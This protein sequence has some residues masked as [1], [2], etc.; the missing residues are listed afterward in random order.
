[1]NTIKF[2]QTFANPAL[3]NFF[4][5]FTNLGGETLGVIFA[6]YFLWFKD[7]RYGYKLAFGLSFS[8]LINNFIKIIVN[9]PRPIGTKGIR[10]LAVNTA[11]GTSFPSGHSQGNA[12]TFTSLFLQFKTKKVLLISI[13]MM[14]LIPISRLYLGVHWPIDVVCGSIFGIIAVLISNFIYEQAIKNNIPYLYLI[15]SIILLLSLIL[16]RS[17][18]YIKAIGGFISISLGYYIDTKY[19]KYNPN[20]TSK[21]NVIKLFLGLFGLLIVL[22]LCSFI[23][24]KGYIRDFVKYFSLGI[25]ASCIAPLIFMKLKLSN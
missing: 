4:I 5:L 2:I 14:I 19:I 25:W 22:S 21:N 16:F 8:L 13:I 6:I 20:S 7:K 23:I 24:P 11:T 12:A 15:L 18:D 3:D 1:M 10:S 9:S 17:S